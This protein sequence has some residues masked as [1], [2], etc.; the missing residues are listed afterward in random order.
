M[1]SLLRVSFTKKAV[2]SSSALIMPRMDPSGRMSLHWL[3][4]DLLPVRHLS[5]LV[6][7]FKDGCLALIAFDV[8]IVV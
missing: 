6:C 5:H 4:A 8:I 3:D 1:T 7:L 2:F